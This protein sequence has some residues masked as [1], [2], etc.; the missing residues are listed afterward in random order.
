MTLRDCTKEEL[1]FVIE[2]LQF[3]HLSGD[4]YIQRALCDVA[5]QREERKL[6]DARRLT[7]V[8]LQNLQ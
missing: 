1:I 3:Y 8:R 7:D 4:Y 6:E 2:R 5:E